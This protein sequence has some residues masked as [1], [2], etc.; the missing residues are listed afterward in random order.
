MKPATQPQAE[1][2]DALSKKGTCI[3]FFSAYQDFDLNRMLSLCSPAGEIEFVPLGDA[4]KGMIYETGKAIWAAVLD[5]FPDLDNT[6]KEQTFNKVDNTVTCTVAIFGKQAK[7]FGG[8]PSKGLRFDSDHIF[9]F[10]F[11]EKGKIDKVTVNWDF[12]AFVKQLTGA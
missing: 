9:I 12:D 11:D 3:E 5:A 4:G 2:I 1:S 7:D 6:V 10:R 8:I